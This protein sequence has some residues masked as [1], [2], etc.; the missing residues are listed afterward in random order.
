MGIWTIGYIV[1]GDKENPRFVEVYSSGPFEAYRN[2]WELAAIIEKASHERI[3]LI[4]IQSGDIEANKKRY[5]I[6]D[7]FILKRIEEK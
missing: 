4:V 1:D 2:G 3:A 7:Q 5:K 6:Q